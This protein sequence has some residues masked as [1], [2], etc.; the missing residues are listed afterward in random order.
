MA[1]FLLGRH[2]RMRISA[3][4]LGDCDGSAL[5]TRL[6]RDLWI[7]VAAFVAYL[8]LGQQTLYARDAHV[9]LLRAHQGATL[10]NHHLLFF[11][12]LNLVKAIAMPAGLTLYQAALLY[13]ALSTAIGVGFVHAAHWRL[14]MRRRDAALATAL[15]AC[16]PAVVFFATVVEVHGPFFAFAGAAAWASARFAVA[17]TL[18]ATALLGATTAL[19]QLAHATGA[20]LPLVLLPLAWTVGRRGPARRWLALALVA[21]FLHAAIAAAVPFALRALDWLGAADPP[22]GHLALRLTQLFGTEHLERELPYALGRRALLEWLWPYAPLSVAAWLGFAVASERAR[23]LAFTGMFAAYLTLATV[24]LWPFA[25]T[26]ESGAYLLPLAWPAALLTVA[27]WPRALQWALLALSAALAAVQVE[28]HDRPE[29]ARAFAT[30]LR[31]LAGEPPPM[32]LVGYYDD[33]EALVIHLLP[34]TPFV[35]LQDVLALPADKLPAIAQRLDALIVA[36]RAE[37]RRVYLS[38]DGYDSLASPFFAAAQPLAPALLAHLRARHE[39]LPVTA[40]GFRGFELNP[41]Q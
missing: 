7:V 4:P 19:A 12:G 40:G 2:N 26:G 33:V 8:L 31:A 17:P 14:G 41:K 16:C 3:R 6:P 15:V 24:L 30:G 36:A 28:S 5:V 23:T 10:H 35:A 20:L 38:Q 13:S 34:D 18:A 21:I 32:L 29:P 22:T 1:G 9:L 27:A 37:G 11:P 25:E 39:L